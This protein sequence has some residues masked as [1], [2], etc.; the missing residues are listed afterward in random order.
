MNEM[1][2]YDG[3]F[4]LKHPELREADWSDAE[5]AAQQCEQYTFNRA[6]HLGW[7]WEPT[8]QKLDGLEFRFDRERRELRKQIRTL[9]FVGILQGIVLLTVS[10][11]IVTLL[12]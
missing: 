11:L 9:Q 4:S 1:D 2:F 7:F 5:D 3:D 6:R 10:V 8:R 12:R